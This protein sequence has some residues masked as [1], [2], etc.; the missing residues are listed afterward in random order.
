MKLFTHH[1]SPHLSAYDAEAEPIVEMNTTP[2]ID[3]LLVLIV[4]LIITIPVP[5]NSISL[6]TPTK[7]TLAVQPD[8]VV[9]QINAGGFILW[10]GT[11]LA[12][13]ADLR[14]KVAETAAQANQPELHLQPSPDTP[15]AFVTA[16]LVMAKA[17]GVRKVGVVNG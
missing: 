5:L 15:Y 11:T 14:A 7:Q 3:V 8:I 9:V 1:L 10:G 13:M 12:S 2:L 17:A 6:D 4:M 16:V